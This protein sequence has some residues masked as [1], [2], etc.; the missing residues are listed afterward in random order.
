MTTVD[1][2]TTIKS[3]SGALNGIDGLLTAKQWERAAIV[4]AFTDEV[5]GRKSGHQ[6][7]CRDFAKLGIRGLTRHDVVAE[8]RRIWSNAIA[9]GDAPHIE[10]GDR[11]VLPTIKWPG[12]QDDDGA[13]R[14]T[15]QDPASFARHIN[16]LPAD[17]REVFA[18][19]LAQDLNANVVETI[20][21]RTAEDRPAIVV[22]SYHSTA[23]KAAPQSA[24]AMPPT[25]APSVPEHYGACVDALGHISMLMR[26]LHNERDLIET[27]ARRKRIADDLAVLTDAM[28]MLN[29]FYQGIDDDALDAFLQGG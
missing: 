13:K 27:A 15:A 19:A 8:Y 7:S 5:R 1:I 17:E 6:V 2:P 16:A 3:A 11:V 25:P 10:P 21:E 4:Y 9:S 12:R 24:I 26:T 29:D 28:N 20:V 18:E 22:R 14:Y 23:S